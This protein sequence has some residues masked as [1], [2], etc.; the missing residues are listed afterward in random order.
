MRSLEEGKEYDHQFRILWPD[1][2]VRI[3]AS[4]GAV[5]RGADGAIERLTGVCWDVTDQRAADDALRA[6]L[7][8]LRRSEER[9][10][11]LARRQAAVREEERKRLSVDLHDNIC[12]ELVGIAILIESARQRLPPMPAAATASFD[13]GVRYLNELVE[14]LRLLAHDLRPMALYDLGL[15]GSLRALAQ[16]MSSE[17][18]RIGAEFHTPTP[19]LDEVTEIAVYRVAQEALTNAVRHAQCGN[20]DLELGVIGDTLQLEVRDDGCGFETERRRRGAGSGL[21]SMEERALAIG[22]RIEVMSHPDAGTTVRLICPTATDRVRAAG[23]T[24]A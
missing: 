10:R 14:H 17:R 13:R 22:G 21:L 5:W 3:I 24:T 20:V 23:R 11:R 6:S 15:E 8:E 16:S 4:R 18:T 1:G 9:I 7:D 2:G 19:R 12:Q